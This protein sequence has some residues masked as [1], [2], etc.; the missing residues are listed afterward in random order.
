MAIS[1]PCAHLKLNWLSAFHRYLAS[2]DSKICSSTF[3]ESCDNWNWPVMVNIC[4]IFKPCP[5]DRKT[6]SQTQL[7]ASLK[8]KL[9]CRSGPSN[10]GVL[11][12]CR[13]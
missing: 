6:A 1:V 11:S 5:H 4:W 12:L 9:V 10:V 13:A 7:A 3:L 8:Q 2:R